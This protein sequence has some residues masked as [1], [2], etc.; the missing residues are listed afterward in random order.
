MGD[1]LDTLQILAITELVLAFIVYV[2]GYRVN[3]SYS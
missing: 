2:F 1:K 3:I